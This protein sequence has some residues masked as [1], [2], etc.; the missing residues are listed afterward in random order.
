MFADC[1]SSHVREFDFDYA[2][3]APA[4]FGSDWNVWFDLVAYKLFEEVVASVASHVMYWN[5]WDD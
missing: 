4:C 1:R 5:R 2:R 3:V